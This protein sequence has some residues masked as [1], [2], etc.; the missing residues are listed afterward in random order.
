[1]SALTAIMLISALVAFGVVL[2][3]VML[4]QEARTRTQIVAPTYIVEDAIDYATEHVDPEVLERIRRSGVQRIIEWSTHYL[5][6]LAERVT[7][8]DDVTVVAGGEGNAIEY[9]RAQLARRGHEYAAADVEAVLTTEGH[10]L[11]SIGA[12]GAVADESEL[13]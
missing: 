13:A 5:Q 3:A 4:T 2:V 1:M 9:I 10:Y 6:G 8:R 7:K 12:L 11:H